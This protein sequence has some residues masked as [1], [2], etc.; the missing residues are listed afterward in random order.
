MHAISEPPPLVPARSVS[1]TT[2]SQRQTGSFFSHHGIWAF[3]VRCF[4]RVQFS[5]KA[6]MISLAFL[7]PLLLLAYAYQRSTQAVIDFAQHEL[8]GVQLMKQAE[9]WLIEVQ[10]QRRMLLSGLSAQIDAGAITARL[11]DFKR[12]AQAHPDGLSVDAELAKVERM[13]ADLMHR[14]LE[15]KDPATEEAL[16]TYVDAVLALRA[17]V[18][19]R[20]SLTLDPDQD[21]YYLMALSTDVSS[22]VIESISRSRGLAGWLGQKGSADAAGVRRLYGVVYAGSQRIGDIDNAVAKASEANPDLAKR[23]PTRQAVEASRTFYAAADASWFGAE[24]AADVDKLAAPG[25]AAVDALRA[26]AK[27]S[28]NQLAA[29]IQKRI[30]ETVFQRN[31]MVGASVASLTV[32]GYLFY[33]FFLVMRG[34]LREVSRH[35]V[36]M[37]DGDLTTSPSPWGSDEAAELMLRLAAMQ[38]S[39]RSMVTQV[40]AASS[41]IVDASTEIADGSNDL[42]ARTEQT[43]ANLEESASAMEQIGATVRQTTDNTEQAARL[44]SQNAETARQGGSVIGQMIATMGSIQTASGRI[45]DIIGV[46]DSIAFQTNILALNAAVEAARAGEQGRG[47]AVVASEVRAL[48]GRSAEAAR[49]IKSLIIHSGTEVERGTA[50]VRNAGTAMENIL[51]GTERINQLLLDVAQGSR[52]QSQGIGQIGVAVQELDQSTQQN[53]AMVEQTAAAA[54]SL[55]DQARVLAD[56]VARFRLPDRI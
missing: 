12:A 2:E 18:L 34:G 43:A 15:A 22:A 54:S 50:T 33:C 19:D 14:A 27:E 31:L 20:S 21:T 55:R 7:V 35:L 32:A 51:A 44:A 8:A 25:Q 45:G 52:E 16:Q 48:A 38:D 26:L 28:S 1:S 37:T 39:L 56:Q 30:D 5:A 24:F 3:G 23:L 41:A 13:H 42:S 9:P 46:I 40:R 47:F 6:G 53:A 17:T 49:E 4:R 11:Q 36:A 29:L 10:K